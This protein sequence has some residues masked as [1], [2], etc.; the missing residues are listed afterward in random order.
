MEV[1]E[2]LHVL[3]HIGGSVA[4]SAYGSARSTADVD[5]VADLRA[6]HVDELVRRLEAD[7]Y[8][9]REA[10]LEAISLKRSF[11]LIHLATMVKVDIF[12][13]ERSPFDEQEM[14]RAE[15]HRLDMSEGA[16]TFLLKSPE[17]LVLRKLLWYR[18]GGE[19]SERQWSDVLGVLKV[20]ASRLNGPYLAQWAADLEIDDLL[21]RALAAAN[22]T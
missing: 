16:R 13:P 19:T 5:V 10:I 20:Q 14:R 21:E 8:L 1:L 6:T 15:P 11:N 2:Y 9:N 7:Y 22:E 3:Y 17:D 12:V 4:S 18:Q